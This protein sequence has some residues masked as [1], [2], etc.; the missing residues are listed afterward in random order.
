ELAAARHTEAQLER[1]RLAIE[2]M[3]EAAEG[4][5]ADFADADLAFHETVWE[6][7]GNRI[8][9][10][11]GQAVW[12]ALRELLQRDLER[13]PGTNTAKL[14][15]AQIDSG[16]YDAIASRDAAEAGRIARSSI[17]QRFMPLLEADERFGVSA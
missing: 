13:T 8:L 12:G 1:M 7:S 17:A 15:S 9:L 6:A 16:L 2:H 14:D 10:L 5:A 11:S 4:D 3:R